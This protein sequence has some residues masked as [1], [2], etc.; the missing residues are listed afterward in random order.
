MPA[1]W[2][3][4]PEDKWADNFIARV[5]AITDNAQEDEAAE[6]YVAGVLSRSEGATAESIRESQGY[7]DWV[8]AISNFSDESIKRSV[9]AAAGRTDPGNQFPE[10]YDSTSVGQFEDAVREVLAQK[11]I[12][13]W[14]DHYS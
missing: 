2:E 12:D 5:E 8:E 9:V 14:S 11:F 1:P 4:S 6:A 10:D 13:N 7:N 3:K